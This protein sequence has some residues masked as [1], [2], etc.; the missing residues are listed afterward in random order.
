MKYILST[1]SKIELNMEEHKRDKH[2]KITKIRY[3]I[4]KQTNISQSSSADQ[5]ATMNAD[6]ISLI[7]K[8]EKWFQLAGNV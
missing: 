2:L 7:R 6:E 8:V 5:V 1:E 4:E 3:I